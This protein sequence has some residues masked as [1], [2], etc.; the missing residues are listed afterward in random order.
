MDE[1]KTSSFWDRALR[2]IKGAWDKIASGDD[3]F[4]EV[5]LSPDL[6]E[7]DEKIL[8]EQMQACLEA[9]GG[10]VSARGRAANLGREY[11]GL[12]E[13]GRERFLCI[14]A[15][16][17]DV[18]H[19]EVSEAAKA[20]IKATTH[21]EQQIS[22]ANLRR[23]LIAPRVR[24]LTQFNDLP[25]GVKFLVDLRAK[26]NSIKGSNSGL[27]ALEAD[28]KSLLTSWFD[29]GFLE[30]RQIDWQA[31]AALL[32][33][34]FAYEAVH[35]I[36]G[37]DDLKNRLAPDRRCFAFIHPRMPDEPLIFVWVA[38]VEGMATNI[39]ELLD[40]TAPEQDADDADTA[41]FYSISNAQEGLNG[42]NFGNFLIKQVLDS[43]SS[44]LKGLEQFATLSPIPGLMGWLMRTIDEG[45]YAL[46]KE[47]EADLIM[48]LSATD[49]AGKA[50]K[51][52]LNLPDWHL[53]ERLQE[54]LRVPLMRAAAYYLMRAKRGTGTAADSVAHF[55]LNNGAYIGQ[56]NWGA[57]L[58]ERGLKQSAGIMLNYLYEP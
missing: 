44:E 53:D 4:T 7:R 42:I 38:L 46:L 52:L 14:L 50:L 43:L 39:Q 31:P 20:V 27:I 57:D 8:I 17:F 55:H 24:L 16:T 54:A 1:L 28:L 26:L 37:W 51:T 35:E 32:E 13:L 45:D 2:N 29:V 10:E 21:A 36:Q 40:Q 18:D 23:A 49:D 15:N 11:L 5:S 41:I 19:D 12:S 48:E 58:S 22:E 56:L 6:S 9:R 30:L 3:A 47:S 34:L 25:E 33:K